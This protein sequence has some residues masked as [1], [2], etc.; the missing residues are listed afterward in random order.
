MVGNRR[1][2]IGFGDQQIAMQDAQREKSC[3][4]ECN[5]T[6]VVVER[7]FL[8]NALVQLQA[9]HGRFLVDDDGDRFADRSGGRG[10]K[11]PGI[12][13]LRFAGGGRLGELERPGARAVKTLDECRRNAQDA[14]LARSVQ[15]AATGVVARTNTQRAHVDVGELRGPIAEQFVA[16]RFAVE[17]AVDRL[18]R[19]AHQRESAGA[20]L[21]GLQLKSAHR[22]DQ[23]T[24]SGDQRDRQG[25]A[26]RIA[27]GTAHGESEQRE[28]TRNPCDA[29]ASRSQRLPGA[30]QDRREHRGAGPDERA[31][32]LLAGERHGGDG[33]CQGGQEQQ[34]GHDQGPTRRTR[35][36]TADDGQLSRE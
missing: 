3:H 14:R 21:C 19:L 25:A 32:L 36:P 4:A 9:V 24:G 15:I 2:K 17:I 18:G 31:R 26:A 12:V 27:S 6:T 28:P 10:Q 35:D 1:P 7:E 22:H 34:P 5:R 16:S 33:Q 20:G 30:E 11:L 29:T 23:E 8:A 13:T